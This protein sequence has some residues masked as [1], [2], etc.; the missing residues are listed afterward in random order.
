VVCHDRSLFRAKGVVW[1]KKD[2]DKGIEPKKPFDRE[3]NWGW[4][5]T[6][7]WIWGYGIH[8]STFSSPQSIVFPFL[9][10]LTT[11]ENKGIK[12]L[13]ENIEKLPSRTK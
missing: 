5:E 7:E 11:A 3:A 1:H 13:E 8:L 9:V 6:K 12:I 2:R 10:E 4:S